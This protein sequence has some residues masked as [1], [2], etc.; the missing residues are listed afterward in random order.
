LQE[1]LWLIIFPSLI[2]QGCATTVTKGQIKKSFIEVL[3]NADT[4]CYEMEMYMETAVTGENTNEIVKSNAHGHVNSK[5]KKIKISININETTDKGK[6]KSTETEIYIF[7]AMEY[8][9]SGKNG[10]WIKFEVPRHKLDSENQLKKQMNLIIAS[11]IKNLKEEIFKNL[12]CYLL[13]IEPDKEAFWKVIMEQEE[14]HPLLKMLNLHYE[15]VV[16]QMNM[17]MWIEKKT[18]FPIKCVMQMKAVIEKEIMKKPFK[19]TINVKKTYIYYNHNKPLVIKLPEGAKNARV[20][21]E[22]WE[23]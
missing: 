2:L 9:Q 11:K 22:E 8:I 1:A 6:S 14:E 20:Y 18:F 19:M 15:D 23:D 5:N 12:D 21:R 13:S 16:R 7:D 3:N 17:E 4:Y 10:K